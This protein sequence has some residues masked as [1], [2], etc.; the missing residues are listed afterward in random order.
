MADKNQLIQ[1]IQS[2][3]SSQIAELDFVRDKF[4][5]NYNL[6]H[7]GNQG[8]LMYHR[9]L[10]HIKQT[11]A[12]NSLLQKADSFSI[13]ACIVTAAANGYSLDPADNEVYLIPKGG[14]AV[15]WRQAPAHVKRLKR[16]GQI[17]DA[18]QA[19]LVYEGD[20]FVENMGRVIEHKPQYKSDVIKNG[21]VEFKMKDGK[22]KFFIY[23]K[24]D[25]EAWRAKSDNPKT[26]EKN[27]TNGPYL[28]KSLWDNNTLNGHSPEPGF[29][30]TKIIKHAANEK[31]W[32]SGQSP[33][34]VDTF[35]GVEVEDIDHEEI[36]QKRNLSPEVH[37]QIMEDNQAFEIPKT[38]QA[39]AE[40]NTFEDDEF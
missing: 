10:V 8:E 29:L 38:E 27:G 26:I 28:A 15:L 34:G 17:E 6:C 23:S 19:Q 2:T 22:S 14:K 16:T 18:E 32:A 25:F 21:Y 13:Y 39:P 37:A 1:I 35:N 9:N 36:P 4:I 5:Q 11:I 30:R 33:A 3:P 40:S 20:I 24:R 12:S 7:P 31:C